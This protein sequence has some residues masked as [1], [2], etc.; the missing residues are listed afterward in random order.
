MRIETTAVRLY[1]LWIPFQ[2]NP[3]RL[4]HP[5]K[6]GEIN[7]HFF[8]RFT[9]IHFIIGVFYA[10]LGFSFILMLALALV[11]ELL[12]NPLKAYLPFIFPHATADSF[13]NSLGDT[14]AVIAG[15][16]LLTQVIYKFS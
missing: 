12:E 16:L 3:M 13:K 14:L 4:S 9:L 11:W 1:R 6:K 15:W 2:Y 10:E 7:F 5:S 8:D